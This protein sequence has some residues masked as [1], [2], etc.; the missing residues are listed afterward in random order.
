MRLAAFSEDLIQ[1]GKNSDLLELADGHAVVVRVAEHK[2]AATLPFDQAKDEIRAVLREQTRIDVA[3]E[4]GQKTLDRLNNSGVGM[5][6]IAEDLGY[7]YRNYDALRRDDKKVDSDLLQYVFQLPDPGNAAVDTSGYLLN[8]GRYAVV[9]LS[10]VTSG[11]AGSD[12]VDEG[13]WVEQQSAYGLREMEALI[14]A[15]KETGDVR[16]F[17][18]NL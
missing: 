17:E 3:K 16:I 9:S 12:S 4:E 2:P 10:K 5:Q 6:A 11:N 18:E 1:S 13:A 8:D 15:L 7:E 14:S